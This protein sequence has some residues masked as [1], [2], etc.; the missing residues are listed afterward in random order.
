M[1]HYG[2]NRFQPGQWHASGLI[3]RHGVYGAWSEGPEQSL[4]FQVSFVE[5]Y[6]IFPITDEPIREAVF[7]SGG[8]GRDSE[9]YVYI[10]IYTYIRIC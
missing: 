4:N 6:V 1:M 10:Y 8:G 9:Y 2:C 5:K 3:P 7:F